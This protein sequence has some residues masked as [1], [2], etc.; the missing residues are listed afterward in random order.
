[1]SEQL[2]IFPWN[3]SFSINLPEVDAEH[4][5]LVDLLNQ[6]VRHLT[7][8]ADNLELAAIFEQL[9][10]YAVVHFQSEEARWDEAFRGDSWILGHKQEHAK[11][12]EDVARLRRETAGSP[13]D[14]AAESIA[15]FLTHWLALHI[16][17]SDRRMALAL[18]AMKSGSSLEA[19]KH[20]AEE[21]MTGATRKMIETVMV[22]YDN[23]ASR[24]MQFSREINQRKRLE[25]RLKQALDDLRTAKETAEQSARLKFT[26]LANLNHELCVPLETITTMLHQLLNAGLP[27]E[28][29]NQ[30]QHIDTATRQISAMSSDISVL[31]LLESGRLFLRQEP[32]C[33]EDVLASVVKEVASAAKAKGLS[34]ILDIQ[35]IQRDLLGDSV[36]LEQALRQYASNAVKYTHS[37]LVSLGAHLLAADEGS[38]LIRFEVRDTGI[39]IASEMKD[40]LFSLFDKAKAPILEHRKGT[41]LGLAVASRI[42]HRMG[43]EVGVESVLGKGST[44][45]LTARFKCIS[46]D[47]CLVRK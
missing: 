9:K 42:A 45:W 5:R 25:F 31:S 17:E 32:I 18:L 36:R 14:E 46:P 40:G 15:C 4:R 47:M 12:V 1:M 43:G 33:I 37:G 3:D 26:H 27:L 29:Q 39:G 28:Q 20:I 16:L 41:G 38:A 24:T 23:L 6:L 44:F 8:H 7:F 10:D 35:G 22:M 11:F 13:F 19:A 34:L 2:E 30:L 21:E